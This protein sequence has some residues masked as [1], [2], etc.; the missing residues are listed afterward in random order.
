MCIDFHQTRSVGEGSD[1]LQL[2]KFCQRE[3]SLQRAENVWLR[4]TT[5]SAQCLRL[6]ERFFHLFCLP[7]GHVP[8]ILA[9]KHE[10]SQPYLLITHPSNPSCV[11]RITSTKFLHVSTLFISSLFSLLYI[12]IFNTVLI[13]HISVA[14]SVSFEEVH[15]LHPHSRTEQL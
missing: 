10:F 3:G 2:I 5:A 6:S 9:V 4:L 14:S 13:N 12:H 1:R 15:V 8:S 11:V 7:P